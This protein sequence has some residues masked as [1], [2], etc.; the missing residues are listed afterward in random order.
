[1]LARDVWPGALALPLP[2]AP[3]DR[4]PWGWA[5]PPQGLDLELL[6]VTQMSWA[7]LRAAFPALSP[8]QLHRLLTQYQLASAMGPMSSWEP[9]TQDCPEAFKSGE[10]P[11]WTG[12]RGPVGSAGGS[13]GLP[14]GLSWRS[15]QSTWHL[16]PGHLPPGVPALSTLGTSTV[17]SQAAHSPWPS[18]KLWAQVRGPPS[19]G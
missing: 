5:L 1:M 11:P 7:N 3:R 6:L 13:G 8:A 18:S 10:P 12:Y 15:L 19:L 17:R 2:R 14:R 9:G 4:L 16:H